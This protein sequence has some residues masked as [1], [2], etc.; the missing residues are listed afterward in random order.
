MSE[1]SPEPLSPEIETAPRRTISLIWAFPLIAVAVALAL[2]W[3]DYASRGPVI[4]ITFSTAAGLTAGETSLR[5]RN[6]DVGQV[7][8]IRF[9]EDLSHVIAAIR[10]DPDIAPYIDKQAEFWVVRPE[11]SSRGV[12]GLETVISGTYVEGMWDAVKGE[13][14]RKFTA[15]DAPP[16]TPSDT[17]GRRIRLRSPDGGS[18]SI[19]APVF[20]R[21]VEVGKVESKRLSDN[22]E[23]V[24]FDVF[25]NAPNDMRLTEQTRF[26]VVSGVDFSF[27]ADGARFRIGSL[28]AL[29]QGGVSFQDFSDGQAP[30]V[31]QN[32]VFALY[33]SPGDARSEVLT[34]DPGRQLQL[35]IYFGRSVRGLSVGAPVEYEGIR[36][37]RVTDI[38]ADVDEETGKF[39][40]RTTIGISPTLLDLDD[41]DLAGTRAFMERAVEAGLRAQLTQG[42]LLTGA[43]IVRLVLDE[44]DAPARLD[45]DS[46]GRLRMPSIPSDLDEITGSVQGTLRRIEK[47]PIEAIFDNVVVLLENINKVVG[48]D[49]LREAPESAVAALDAAT[50]LLTA[51]GLTAAPQQVTDL[52]TK[53]NELAGSEEFVAAKTDLAASLASFRA[54]LASLEQSGFADDAAGAAA[55]LRARLDD[56]ELQR[57]TGS[58]ANAMDAAAVLLNDRGLAQTPEALNETLASLNALL[59]DPAMQAAPGELQASLASLRA[60]LGD[61]ERENA[62]AEL[63]AS[64][65]ALRAFLDDPALRQLAT[66]AAGTATALRTLLDA[67][68]ADKLPASAVAA[69]NSSAALFDRIAEQ[70]LAGTAAAALRSIDEATT[71]VSQAAKGTPELVRRLS[72]LAAR[73]DNLLA[74]VDVG[75][76]LNYEAV[77]AIREI[78]DAARAVSDLADL[79]ERQPNSLILGR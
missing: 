50:A 31:E 37:G 19:G 25:V 77:A 47:L 58:A 61:L 60:L 2:L 14:K 73:A 43:L 35:D 24:E 64:L 32:H 57:L 12:S 9:S 41:D 15:L 62:A 28:G 74:S 33:A 59:S 52:L 68:E 6:V 55:A 10:I 53:L 46:D 48:S 38:T 45:E 75:S 3:R 76:E 79:V 16:L 27:G 11:V 13:A 29:L 8:D 63:A 70:D 67:P 4:E 40:T 49:A 21:R 54:V 69:L 23:D 17:P 5:Y 26:W 42:S 72:S 44:T 20:Y 18:I 22:G 51:P 66:E 34:M 30:Q 71:A 39:S 1:Q 78:R 36:V 56:P 65:Q 7:E